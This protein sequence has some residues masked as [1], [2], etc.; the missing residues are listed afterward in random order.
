[1]EQVMPHHVQWIKEKCLTF[2][3]EQ[4]KLTLANGQ[5]IEYDILV[6]AAGLQQNFGAV[7]GLP[8]TMGKNGVASIYSFDYSPSVW[9]NITHLQKGKAIFTNPATAVNC[10][11]APQKIC[12]LAEAAW[13]ERGVRNNIDIEF[14]TATPGIFACP[15][16]RVALEKVMQ[17]KNI[18]PS[19]K[20]NLVEVDGERKIATFEREGELVTKEFD[21]LHVTP[22]MSAPD[23][24][25]NSPL[26]NAAGFVD[27]DKETCQHNKFS[28]VFSLGDCS[29]LPTSK[30]YSAISSQAPVVT[31]NVQALMAGK[32]PTSVYDGYTACPVLVGDSK[33]MLAEFNGYTMEAIPTFKPL[34]QTKPNVLFYWLKRYIFEHVYWH[35][36]PLG[37]WYGKYM[38]FE[39]PVKHKVAEVPK[40]ST[41]KASPPSETAAL[42]ASVPI[43]GVGEASQGASTAADSLKP[44]LF[45]VSTPNLPG[46]VSLSGNM[47]VAIIEQLAPRY[48]G[49]L[50]LNPAENKHFHRKAIEAAGC[51]VEVAPIP[52]PAGGQP[53]TAEHAEAVLAA[54][55]RLPRPLMIQCTSG[56][57][58]GA[59]L[60]LAQAKALGHNRASA[61]LLAED[62]DLKF[63][64]KCSECGPIKDW[65][66][67]QLPANN[68]EAQQT[69][70][71][72]KGAV[73]EQ[74]FDPQGS[75]TFSY[76]IGCS[77]SQEAVLIDPVLGME[78]RDLSLAEELGF[79][80]KYVVNTHCHADHITSGGAIKKQLP[81]V[82]TMISEASGAA[83]D[84]K[85]K[86]GD[87]IEFGKYALQAVATPG[88]TDGCMCFVLRGPDAPKAVFTGDTLLI[89]GCGRTDFQQGDASRL[90][91]V[92]HQKIFTLP[93]DTK[94]YPGHDY[95]GRNVSTVAEEKKFNPRL[96]QNKEGFI[97]TM[98]DLKLPYPKMMD[99]AVPANLVCGV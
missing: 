64:T 89:R 81:E 77:D 87:T 18:T 95:K 76:L 45:G 38:W 14:C 41:F 47:D 46:D 13:R 31:Y 15:E 40:P 22:P 42:K 16:Y 58:A 25:R 50:Y 79:K 61:S 30:T 57:R 80:V 20:T 63:F 84:V 97:K 66:L 67:D 4:N 59:A 43:S 35:S 75:S 34:D 90:Y 96:T 60:L 53:A 44:E 7:A 2:Q 51:K 92:V 21:F 9:A 72:K 82:K 52:N 10:G 78:S 98:Q 54:M 26:A 94:I 39:P 11:G 28:N 62:L 36:M 83:A 68:E 17:S 71:A 32:E 48:K 74:L 23:F 55:E 69:P 93:E 3:P 73:I 8:E 86:D 56:N 1:M 99:E 85:L 6:V 24:I 33:L 12:Y 27:V 29:S 19:V 88:H 65:V 37:R 70:A 91:D 49:W 5:Q